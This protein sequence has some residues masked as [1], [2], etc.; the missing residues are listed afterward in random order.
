[1]KNNNRR[2]KVK[3]NF[4]WDI[5]KEIGGFIDSIFQVTEDF[6]G[7][8]LKA[9][10]SFLKG[11]GLIAAILIPTIYVGFHWIAP[12]TTMSFVHL[13][14]IPSYLMGWLFVY[15]FILGLVIKFLKSYVRNLALILVIL[16]AIGQSFVSIGLGDYALY[17]EYASVGELG[18]LPIPS[19]ESAK[20]LPQNVADARLRTTGA[21]TGLKIKEI[22]EAVIFT[23]QGESHIGYAAIF[24]PNDF[25]TRI[26]GQT[27]V[28]YIDAHTGDLSRKKLNLKVLPGGTFNSD[29]HRSFYATLPLYDLT[30]QN[31]KVLIESDPREEVD[32]LIKKYK[33]EIIP[34]IN[35]KDD[36]IL[37]AMPVVTPKTTLVGPFPVS[38]IPV[39]SGVVLLNPVNGSSKYLTVAEIQKDPI[40]S[41]SRLFPSDLAKQVAQA[42]RF[43][44]VKGILNFGRAL[45]P[46]SISRYAI[47]ELA[48]DPEKAAEWPSL[49]VAEKDKSAYLYFPYLPNNSTTSIVREVA[50]DADTGKI[51][52]ENVHDVASPSW[53][54]KTTLTQRLSSGQI[55][56]SSFGQFDEPTPLEIQNKRFFVFPITSKNAAVVTA[57]AVT[58]AQIEVKTSQ[59]KTQFFEKPEDIVVWAKN[60]VFTPQVLKDVFS[61]I[62]SLSNS[63][64]LNQGPNAN[65]ANLE[66][67]IDNLTEQM[68]ALT[69]AVKS[70]KK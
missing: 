58:N 52:V 56:Q 3:T 36:S 13:L 16:F 61:G 33:E 31:S 40:L 57:Y 46:E 17:T 55:I 65:S 29:P 66:K 62:S 20:F 24:Q 5:F 23:K 15:L 64:N 28:A 42:S 2:K 44:G 48:P 19:I 69:E 6:A 54:V 25:E 9:I 50:I 8:V 18:K 32:T 39:Y 4:L 7:S 22:D 35:E 11:F 1:V 14:S 60:P 63:Q 21:D 47:Y 59:V 67:K 43:A 51:S 68:K 70:L 38:N 30:S 49:Y 34:I 12:S 10:G 53:I 41:K 26:T 37:F 27:E 45:L